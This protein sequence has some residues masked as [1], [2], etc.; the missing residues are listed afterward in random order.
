MDKS[1]QM[2]CSLPRG[3][4]MCRC[5]T[6]IQYTLAREHDEIHPGF[7][8][9]SNN[10]EIKCKLYKIIAAHDGRVDSMS[11]HYAG[12]LLIEFR[13]VGKCCTTGES[14]E[15]IVHRRARVQARDS[16]WL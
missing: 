2:P 3:G 11:A 16:P 12:G 10:L 6:K 8:I 1:A 7:E 14:E 13:Q 4:S 9:Y 15:S 5:Q